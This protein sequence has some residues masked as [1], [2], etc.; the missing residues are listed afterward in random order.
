MIRNRIALLILLAFL[1][2]I[3]FAIFLPIRILFDV[4]NSFGFC[5]GL[6]VLIVYWKGIVDLISHPDASRAK[7]HFLVLGVFLSWI[8]VL[9]RTVALEWWRL[10]G[11]PLGGLD[12]LIMATAAFTIIIGGALH[13][14]A[15]RVI[16]GMV[17]KSSWYHL[18]FALLAGL[19]LT[20]AT[21]ILRAWVS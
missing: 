8:A 17:P 9:M 16:E 14:V 11:S 18:G 13:L 4:L 10:L 3:P 20:G 7:A 21:L 2:Y 6:A 5:I 19:A 1:V 15:P 12:N